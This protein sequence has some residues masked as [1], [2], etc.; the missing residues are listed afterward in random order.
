MQA[1]GV[2][3]PCARAHIR[4]MPLLG[5]ILRPGLSGRLEPRTVAAGRCPAGGEA[6]DAQ[7]RIVAHMVCYFLA[8]PDHPI[9]AVPVDAVRTSRVD[10]G[11]RPSGNIPRPV[12]FCHTASGMSELLEELAGAYPGS[13]YAPASSYMRAPDSPQEVRRGRVDNP[14][15]ASGCPDYADILVILLARP[16]GLRPSLTPASPA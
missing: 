6:V 15:P 2:I 13:F 7:R 10:H 11:L 16:P 9:P 3:P 1:S 12:T 4:Q 5:Q 14:S 8:I